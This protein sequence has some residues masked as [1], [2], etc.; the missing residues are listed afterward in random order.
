MGR[1]GA[2]APLPHARAALG[3]QRGRPAPAGA[4]PRVARGAGVWGLRPRRGLR[5]HA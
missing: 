3:G 1:A 4:G 5:R 2:G